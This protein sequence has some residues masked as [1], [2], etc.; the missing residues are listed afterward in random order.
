MDERVFEFIGDDVGNEESVVINGCEVIVVN[1]TVFDDI[2]SLKV[3]VDLEL[4]SVACVVSLIAKI[5]EKRS[6]NIV[7][8]HQIHYTCYKPMHTLVRYDIATVLA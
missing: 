8:S 6:V 4:T 2:E 1:D 3:A 7:I 5:K